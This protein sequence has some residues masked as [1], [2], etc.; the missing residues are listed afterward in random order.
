[1]NNLQA[2]IFDLDGTLIDSMGIWV[3]VDVE[4]LTR[5]GIPATP[6]LFSNV[7]AGNSFHELAHYVKNRFDLPDS[8][9]T[10]CQEWTDMVKEHYENDIE[11]KAGVRELLEYL[12]ASHI[13][14]AIGTSN[15][16]LLTEA[17]LVN[18]GIRDFFEVITTGDQNLRGKPYP[19]IFLTAAADLNVMPENCLVVEDTLAG[20]RSAAAAGMKVI[21]IEE[22]ESKK[23]WPDIE[24]IAI[25]SAKEII[26]ISNFIK[27]LSRY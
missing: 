16:S 13:K 8:I 3:K 23:D 5:R 17:V 14:M 19:D 9:E 26:D 6:D 2:V 27:N 18:N 22:D 1:M 4:Y 10:I 7:P 11:L 20:A 12:R 25:F 24:K 21:A 15:S